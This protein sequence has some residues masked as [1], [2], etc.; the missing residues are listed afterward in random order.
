MEMKTVSLITALLLA[1]C[2]PAMAQDCMGTPDAYAML[3]EQFGEA[4]IFLGPQ[5]DGSVIE[6]WV[7]EETWTLFVTKEGMSCRLTSGSGYS[8]PVIPA[9]L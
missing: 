8:R 6:L 9:N 1:T 7:G 3:S 2:A 5:K 4:P